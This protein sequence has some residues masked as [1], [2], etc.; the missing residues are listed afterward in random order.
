[1]GIGSAIAQRSAARGLEKTTREVGLAQIEAT[2]EAQARLDPFAAVGE[3]VLNEL[4]DFV[5]QGPETDFER[6]QGFEAIQKSASA[7]RRLGSGETLKE[8]TRFNTGLNERFRNQRFNELFNLANL[9]QASAA[10]V[11]NIGIRGAE[12]V[13]SQT[14]SGAN[15]KAAGL[16]GAGN[17]LQQGANTA[18]QFFGAV[19]L[20]GHLLHPGAFGGRSS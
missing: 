19:E 16:I 9:G 5:S 13:A 14:I 4:T 20:L 2:K 10:G 18:F 1:M 7:G 3:G 6:T 15:V 17:T 12:N 8:L 11:A